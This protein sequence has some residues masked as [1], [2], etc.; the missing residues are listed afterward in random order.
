MSQEFC[1]QN[2]LS[3]VLTVDTP[4][5]GEGRGHALGARGVGVAVEEGKVGG[6]K[7]RSVRHPHRQLGREVGLA[8]RDHRQHV[9]PDSKQ[10][11]KIALH[12]Y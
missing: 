3:N 12:I 9:V 11:Y 6:H 1:P 8:R 10:A 4:V 5:A 2:S 7:V